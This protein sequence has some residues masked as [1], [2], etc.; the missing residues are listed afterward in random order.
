MNKVALVFSSDYELFGDGS[1]DVYREQI[2][3]IY[4]MMKLFSLYNAKLTIF[5]EYGQY[6]A[7][8]E[9]AKDNPLLLESNKAVEKQ[10]VDLI[11][12]GHDVQLHY[13]GQ[14]H[15]AI[16]DSSI[17][18]FKLNLD[19]VDITSLDEH[20]LFEVL[21]E[22]KDFLE[23]LLR[24][25]KK[26][27]TC[28]SFRAGSWSVEN[29]T[30]LLNSLRKAGFRLDSSVIPNS[31]YNSLYV[32]YNYKDSPHEYNYWLV[33]KYISKSSELGDMIEL[34]IFTPRSKFALLKYMSKKFFL[35]KKQIKERYQNSIASNSCSI[36]TRLFRI[37]TKNTYMADLNNITSP[38]LI[39]MVDDVI[40]NQSI[41]RAITPLMFISHSKNTYD[42]NELKI[43]LEYAKNSDYILFW[44]LQTAQE[45]I[46]DQ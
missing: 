25:Y 37:V 10:L 9:Y 23:K 14:W 38:N 18:K 17:N 33:D 26:T 35:S 32:N 11:K 1:G 28:S 19:K 39:K 40:S 22:G 15:N 42:I 6:K 4:D 8:A 30:K 29:E 20:D 7:Y 45:Y 36:F 43:F 5:F 2:N 34:P 41:T 27:Y 46:D 44:T 12:E 21:I 24:K 16:Y 31:A 13:H 3:P